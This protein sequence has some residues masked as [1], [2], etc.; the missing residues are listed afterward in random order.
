MKIECTAGDKMGI[1]LD[2]NDNYVINRFYEPIHKYCMK[3]ADKNNPDEWLKAVV[4]LSILSAHIMST[5]LPPDLT[6]DKLDRAL[7]D[8][9][10]MIKNNNSIV[11]KKYV[12]ANEEN[13]H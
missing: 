13:M 2:S 8:I 6:D 1:S 10:I 5:I 12:E 9:K 11:L 4:I 7:E 3:I